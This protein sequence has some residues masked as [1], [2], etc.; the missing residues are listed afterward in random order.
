M[1]LDMPSPLKREDQ[2]LSGSDRKRLL[3]IF[4]KHEDPLRAVY[5]F[6]FGDDWIHE[7][8][9]MG[10][11]DRC[12]AMSMGIEKEGGHKSVFCIAGEGAP[13]VGDCGGPCGFEELKVCCV[14]CA[15]RLMYNALSSPL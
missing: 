5:T 13:A 4:A 1:S 15:G 8:D 14:T 3:D 2:P 6:D 11:A 7:I 12:L 9:Y 10:P